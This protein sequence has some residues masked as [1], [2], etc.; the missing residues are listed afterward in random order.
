MLFSIFLG[1]I[2]T[3]IVY[4]VPLIAATIREWTESSKKQEVK[5][6]KMLHYY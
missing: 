3:I 5:D 4:A 6:P 2:L 1:P